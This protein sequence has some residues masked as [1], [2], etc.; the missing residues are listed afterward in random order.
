MKKKYIIEK[1]FLATLLLTSGSFSKTFTVSNVS[2]LRQALEDSALNGEDDT[3][4]LKAGVYK[5]TSDALGTFTFTDD[6]SKKL[7]IQANNGLTSKDVILSGDNTDRVLSVNGSS[8]FI[9]K[10][11][12]IRNGKGATS[13]T[14]G[15]LSV[16]N[17]MEVYGCNFYNN[18][19]SYRGGA[20]YMGLG[21]IINSKIHDNSAPDGAGIYI[22]W[23]GIFGD[24]KTIIINSNFYKNRIV[25]NLFPHSDMFRTGSAIDTKFP[26]NLLVVN[27]TF[28]DND[29]YA[30]TSDRTT[31]LINNI[32]H[33]N[34]KDVEFEGGDKDS[35]YNN[36]VDY[37]KVYGLDKVVKKNNF[38]P[39]QKVITFQENSFRLAKDSV[40]VDSGLNITNTVFKE[41]VKSIL[42]SYDDQLEDETI[43]TEFLSYLNRDIEGNLRTVNKN[44]DLGAYEYDENITLPSDSN[45]DGSVTSTPNPTD[46]GNTTT[47][48]P[49]HCCSTDYIL[50]LF[51]LFILL[52]R[53]QEKK[54]PLA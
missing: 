50:P 47:H 11:I 31:I 14:G 48:T 13:E 53:N 8:I 46:D 19:T 33:N 2:E 35:L 39:T 25:N 43:Y 41:L 52:Y 17:Y 40:A 49:H 22:G 18:T 16:K 6:E 38:Q 32:F 1:V 28:I 4:E 44:I 24:E 27:S 21:K 10:N 20:I 30:I 54:F 51:V 7:T 36:Y 29:E 3:I 23:G 15:G 37:T 26:V 5:T 9:L 45:D 12:S 34:Y 42:Y